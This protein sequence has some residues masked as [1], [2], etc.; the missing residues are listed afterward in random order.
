MSGRWR[1]VGAAPALT[2]ILW[3]VM[4]AMALA[5]RPLLP[6]DETRYAAVAWEMWSR[7]DY[8]VPHLNGAPYSHKPPLLFWLIDAGWQLGGPS[9][10]WLRLVGPLCAAVDLWLVHL[11]ARR[12]W[13]HRPEVARLAPLVLVGTLAWTVYGTLLLFDSLLTACVL[14]ALLGLLELRAGSRRGAALLAL[15]LGMGVLAKGPAVLLHL[16]PTALLAFWWDTGPAGGPAGSAGAVTPGGRWPAGQSSPRGPSW[17]GW[18]SAGVAGGVALALLWAVPA[19]LAGGPAYGRE[20]FL[21]QTTGRMVRSFAH[22]RPTWW[23]LP[24]LLW[25][26]IP[27]SVWPAVWRGA[28]RLRAASPD[29]GF[30][31]CVAWA[32]PAIVAFSLVSGK[33]LHYLIP[34]L[35]AIAL[36]VALAL[37]SRASA[38][39]TSTTPS[40]ARPVSTLWPA[41]VLA[42]PGAALL[43]A[44][45][46]PTRLAG[47]L[48][49]DIVPPPLWAVAL[50]ATIPPAVVLAGA[51]IP[52]RLRRRRAA[53][54]PVGD[55]RVGGWPPAAV[56]AGTVALVALA[57]A[58][59]LPALAPR[60][61]LGAVSRHLGALQ[62][63]GVPLAHVTPYAGQYTFL[64]RLRRPL[65]EISGN[66]AGRWLTAHPGGR[67]VTYTRGSREPDGDVDF[68]QRYRGGWVVIRRETPPPIPRLTGAGRPVGP[69]VSR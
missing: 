27:W 38:A 65:D 64:G 34:E 59:A 60:Y 61:D 13:P 68:A 28:R 45:L 19:A 51:W 58:V 6:V 11:L 36:L 4:T 52:P 57:H 30:R 46:L 67:V 24:Q 40:A 31:F 17:A 35:P 62:R 54:G 32:L 43:L 21:G 50:L 14:A 26:L 41:L 53:A 37:T 5:T 39:V 10:L 69:A 12:L 25:M 63:A 9:L 3:L 56:A 29:R 15:G 49:A 66:D 7:G 44:E 55:G 48:P 22:Q 16:L 8:L 33:Q 20:I 1:A 42:L 23:Y 18:V 47:V 2:A